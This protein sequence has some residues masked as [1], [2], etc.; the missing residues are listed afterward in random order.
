MPTHFH[1]SVQLK[2]LLKIR[3]GH[4]F[5]KALAVD[6]EL[7]L[8]PTQTRLQKK[9]RVV[10]PECSVV[11]RMQGN[12]IF[13][14][15]ILEA[16]RGNLT[17]NSPGP[18]GSFRSSPPGGGPARDARQWG[19]PVVGGPWRTKTKTGRR[20]RRTGATKCL[21]TSEAPAAG[22]RLSKTS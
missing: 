18:A 20:T 3:I 13:T 6:V 8:N 2:N 17:V 21:P 16:H 1:F 15:Q 22:R 7:C 10:F 4:D 5:L 9:S 11:L 19:G 14:T 12:G